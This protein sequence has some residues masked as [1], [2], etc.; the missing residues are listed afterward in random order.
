MSAP[1]DAGGNM[2]RAAP[3]AACLMAAALG[4]AMPAQA[5]EARDRKWLV[6]YMTQPV[7]DNERNRRYLALINARLEASGERHLGLDLEWLENAGKTGYR[8]REQTNLIGAL[9]F[10]WRTPGL[11]YSGDKALL[12]KLRRAY[13][14]VAAHVTA[15]GQFVWPGDQDMYWAGSHEHAWRLEPVLAGYVCVGENFTP[16]ERKTIEGAIQRASEWLLRNRTVQWNNRGAVWCAVTTLCGLY[17]NKPEYGA[18]VEANA[19]A[20]MNAV[21]Q[22]DGEVGERTA[23][24]GGG[25]PC[26]N[27]TYTGLSYVYLYRLLSGRDEMDEKLTRAGRWLA[28]YNSASLCPLVPGASVRRAYVN[29]ANMKDILPTMEMLSRRDPFF[30]GVADRMMDKLERRRGAF[31][32]HVISPLIWA[33][34]EPRGGAPPATSP[35]W[36]ANHVSLYERPEVHYALISRRYQTG[37]TFRGRTREGYEFALRGL[38]SFAYGAENPVLMAT[39]DVG[40][41]AVADGIDSARRNVERGPLGW[42]VVLMEDAKPGGVAQLR[43]ITERRG[44]LWTVYAL[45]PSSL[46]AVYGGAKGGWSHRWVM[47]GAFVPPP[48]V[49]ARRRAAFTGRAG[50]IAWLE[51]EGMVEAVNGGKALLV[52]TPGGTAAFGFSNEAFRFE[53]MAEGQLSFADESGRY[54]LSLKAVLDAQGN[55][56]RQG[57]MRL[58]GAGR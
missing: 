6:E 41:A 54:R 24:Y 12:E 25:G 38:Q 19:E 15:E 1:E 57:G 29:P 52:T 34:L 22:E 2:K 16:E 3:W 26:S 44:H 7:Q 30:G 51:G 45:T 49:E 33:M 13:L 27:Y 46:V 39:D 48:T 18:A 28:L 56:N 55:L 40:S 36:Y 14:A 11:K 37:L 43:V 4:L 8:A 47:N 21:V 9:S 23:Q 32:G 35:E 10:C 31:V 50:R 5:R 42:E 17:L 20:I 58:A 53:G